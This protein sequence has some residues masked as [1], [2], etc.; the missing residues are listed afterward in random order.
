M[1]KDRIE[2][3]RNTL[4]ILHE[5]YYELANKKIEVVTN[6]NVAKLYKPIDFETEDTHGKQFSTKIAVVNC[7]TLQ[8]A[9]NEVANATKLGVLNFASAKN[10]GGGFMNGAQSQEESIARSS[11]LYPTIDQFQ[12]M[13]K[14]NR[15]RKTYLYSDYMIYSPKV[16]V[17]KDDDGKLLAKPYEIDVL[18]SPAVNVGAI[19][20]NK[21]AEMEHVNE[22]MIA[23]I[24][25]VLGVFA[26]HNCDTLILGAWGCGVFRNNP[27]DIA[28]HFNSFLKKDAK[29]DGVFKRIVFAVL[30]RNEKGIYR[31]FEHLKND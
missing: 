10:P 28:T 13:Y 16:V 7:T 26:K 25:K 17:F 30:D 9:K 24:D 19:L 23:R 1:K 20:N 4:A 3:A 5:G 2:I 22:V 29:Y 8:A 6:T 18:T 11:S 14:F 15:S 21:P 31:A 12:E 27:T